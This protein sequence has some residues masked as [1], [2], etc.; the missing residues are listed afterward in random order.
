[1]LYEKDI[2]TLNVEF[3]EQLIN[4]YKNLLLQSKNINE[5]LIVLHKIMYKMNYYLNIVDFISE[6]NKDKIIDIINSFN[7]EIFNAEITINNKKYF[8]LPLIKKNHSMI[9]EDLTPF[10]NFYLKLLNK[11]KF[12]D[13]IL[14]FEQAFDNFNYEI[15][16]ISV[17]E[18][19][20]EYNQTSTL[21]NLSSLTVY[22]I[23]EDY[24]YDLV[25]NSK[26]NIDSIIQLK[27]KPKTYQFLNLKIKDISKR[28]ILNKIF[29]NQFEKNV[30]DNPLY[31]IICNYVYKISYFQKNTTS[32]LSVNEFINKQFKSINQIRDF[33]IEF[34][35]ELNDN[36][37]KNYI[38]IFDNNFPDLN[39]INYNDLQYFINKSK[40][41]LNQSIGYFDFNTII[42]YVKKYLNFFNI[43]IEKI[44]NNKFIVYFQKLLIS[45]LYFNFDKYNIKKPQF[46]ILFNRYK[47]SKNRINVI[48]M[49]MDFNCSFNEIDIMNLYKL[50]G[51]IG[52]CIYYS[53]NVNDSLINKLDKQLIFKHL[54]RSILF[55]DIDDLLKQTKKEDIK[56][57]ITDY[58][59]SDIIFKY[60]KH[61]LSLSLDINIFYNTS[62]IKQ[63]IEI[64][65]KLEDN[66]YSKISQSLITEFNKCFIEIYKTENYDIK[67]DIIQLFT[68]FNLKS[69]PF[70]DYNYLYANIISSELF[71]NYTISK[72][73][74]DKLIKYINED[75][76][77]SKIIK[78]N[79]NYRTLI[80]GTIKSSKEYKTL[81]EGINMIIETETI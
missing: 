59:N 27:L 49:K 21:S 38:N 81:T 30:K 71:Y 54:L 17:K 57:Y 42:N 33:I 64:L 68:V 37:I 58:L 16:G 60:K 55:Y 76:D 44:E 48:C 6:N 52:Y 63:I 65:E 24:D 25:N 26:S 11:K 75:I 40:I 2:E 4:K 15:V 8:L 79:P 67:P 50:F 80:Y 18:S 10:Y 36:Y 34:N 43:T 47:I 12:N 53:L 69:L 61:L 45:Q 56:D 14:K 29:N 70:E 74:F 78:R 66:I 41:S 51:Y 28:N 46:N 22:N 3:I 19:N 72:L 62:F 7:S 9:N 31:V 5:L 23:I 32:I 77:I 1:M 20:L 39:T 73:K 35:R 13:E